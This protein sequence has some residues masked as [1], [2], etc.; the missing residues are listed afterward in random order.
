M[1]GG[2]PVTEQFAKNIHADGYAQ[3]AATAVD[4]ARSLITGS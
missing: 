4:I 1:I 2:A 3:D